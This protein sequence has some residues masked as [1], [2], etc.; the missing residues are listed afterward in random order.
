MAARVA[1]VIPVLNEAATIGG[2]LES[3]RA[4]FPAAQLIV[5]DGGSDDATAMCATPL[6]DLFLRGARGR[7]RQMNLGAY[8]ASADYVFFLHAD[9]CPGTAATDLERD[10]AASPAW[11]FAPLRL[12]GGAWPFRVIEYFINARSRFTGVGTGDQMLYLRRDVF[13][14]QGGFDDIPLME[15]VALCKRLRR[16][17]RPHLLS[18]PV[19]TSSRR[20]EEHGIARTVLLMWRLRLAYFLGAAPERLWRR[21]YGN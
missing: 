17:S 15:D 1:F 14:E 2:L 11:G 8:G 20:W 7:A 21:Y 13:V 3:L 18:H 12:S 4:A 19:T 16:V 5:V 6:C 9:S 10:L